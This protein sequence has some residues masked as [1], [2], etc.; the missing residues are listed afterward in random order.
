MDKVLLDTD[1]ISEITKNVNA[2]VKARATHYR[3]NFGHFTLSVLS[4]IEVVKGYH[5]LQRPDRIARFLA[6]LANEE[7]LTLSISTS[8]LAG[9]IFADLELA[10]RPIGR[11]DPMIAAIAIEHDLTLV[12]G[13]TAHYQHIQQLGYPLILDNWRS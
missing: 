4:I 9:R 10:G 12:T 11:I 8:E 7:V 1:T 13:N 3:D 6:S 2:T 5:R